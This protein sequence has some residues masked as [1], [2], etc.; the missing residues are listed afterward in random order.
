MVK[1][2]RVGSSEYFLFGHLGSKKEED[3]QLQRLEAFGVR[4]EVALRLS[5]NKRQELLKTLY[6]VR[7]RRDERA[8]AKPQPIDNTASRRQ[9][10]LLAS[11]GV[12]DDVLVTFSRH[13][14]ERQLKRY[15][16]ALPTE[17][18]FAEL[19]KFGIARRRATSRLEA[20]RLLLDAQQTRRKR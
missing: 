10:Q 18:Q 2:C 8:H 12:P 3:A 7:V 6:R 16:A 5:A 13:S 9:L 4:R 20:A 14:A 17:Q 11:L 1:S 19:H 15:E